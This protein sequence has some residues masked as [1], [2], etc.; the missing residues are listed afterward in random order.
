MARRDTDMTQGEIWRHFVR[1]SVPLAI[2][3]LFQQLYNTVDSVVVGQYVGKEA[4]AA[5]GSTGSIIN[6]LIGLFNGLSVGAGVVISQSFGSHDMPR[7]RRAVHT[8]VAVTFVLCAVATA[9]GLC[10]VR[11]M[12]QMMQTPDDVMGEASRYL[13][14]YF[15]GISGLLVYNMGSAILR[16]VGDSRRPLYFLVF[17]ALTNTLLD[18]LFV[19]VFRLGVAGV[20]LATII[21]QGLSAV[22]VL[23][24]LTREKGDYGIRWKQLGIS[25]E[26]LKQVFNVG[27]PSA[28]QQALT[29]FSNVFVQSYINAFGSAGMA[30]WSGY[31]K[32]DA[33]LTV[34]VMAIAQASTT[35]VGQNWGAR[36]PERARQG[37]R[38]ALLLAVGCTIVLTILML[39]FAR[40]LMGLF[41]NEADVIDYGVRYIQLITPFYVTI[42][43]NQIFGGALRGIGNARGP[44]LIMLGSFVVFRQIYLY[45]THLLG[46]GFVA[47]ALAYPMGWVVCS[48][49][50]T[51]TY[52]RSPLYHANRR[53]ERAGRGQKGIGNER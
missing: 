34:P 28:V 18:L 29:S 13:T 3:L 36:K 8:T 23:A 5:V 24:T 49:C 15:A 35:F 30:G 37:V 45:V 19:I 16:A 53:L 48:S 41:S 27:A 50:L 46:L 33:F 32:L 10:I 20:A 26:E 51:I 22:L 31:N 52:L 43:F 7:L 9:L 14:I 12:L 6:M 39:L 47:V 17:S 2:G 44:M 38:L 25:R 4:L 11:P 1:F 42:C 40:P 21:A